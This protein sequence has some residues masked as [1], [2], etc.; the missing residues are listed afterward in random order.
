MES[1]LIVKIES[2]PINNPLYGK[3][4]NTVCITEICEME[5]F[6]VE[7]P[8]FSSVELTFSV[9]DDKY[10]VN[11]NA[12]AFGLTSVERTFVLFFCDTQHRVFEFDVYADKTYS[13]KVYLNQGDFED[14]KDDYVV[15]GDLNVVF[16]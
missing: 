11:A 13:L 7:M 9:K 1:K 12:V 15:P 10:T 3:H 8:D 14:D 16:C 2:K 5:K 4:S 6:E